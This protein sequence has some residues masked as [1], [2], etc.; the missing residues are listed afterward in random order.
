MIV[1]WRREVRSRL[2]ASIAF[3]EIPP[4]ALS[5]YIISTSLCT[6][7]MFFICLLLSVEYIFRS[8]TEIERILRLRLTLIVDLDCIHQLVSIIF[9]ELLR[10]TRLPGASA[11]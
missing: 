8:G 2:S 7:R 10:N 6:L 4:S 1:L 5:K 9:I 3:I 11:Y